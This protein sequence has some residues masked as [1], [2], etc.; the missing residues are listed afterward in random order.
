[1]NGSGIEQGWI[2][3]VQQESQQGTQ[4]C[5]WWYQRKYFFKPYTPLFTLFYLNHI[6]WLFM[7][8]RHT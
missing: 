1:L 5:R 6:C 4:L 8:L 7:W 2:L 3:L